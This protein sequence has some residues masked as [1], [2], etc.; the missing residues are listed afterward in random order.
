VRLGTL[1]FDLP[2]RRLDKGGALIVIRPGAVSLSEQPR[3]GRS[4][5]AEIRKA[6]Y[7]GSHW[8]YTL[9]TDVAELFIIQ[10][11]DRRHAV[12]ASVHLVLDLDHLTLVAAEG[13]RVAESV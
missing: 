2:A 5:P 4:L 11:I 3:Q 12:G 1:T 7:L 6:T 9:S 13:A 10:P 8:E